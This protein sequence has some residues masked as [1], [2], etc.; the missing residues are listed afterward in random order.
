LGA[1]AKGGTTPL[2]DVFLYG[3]RITTRGFVFMDTPGFDPPCTTGL[4]AGGANV[5]V[6]TT[7]RGSVLGLKPTPCIKV[8]TNTPMYERMIDD[9]DLDA[10][11]ILEG[12]PVEVA[13][14]R[15]F[16]LI[17]EVADGRETKSERSG[18]GEEEFA[19]WQIGPIL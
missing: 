9:M 3:E 2:M 18:I 15:I 16:E 4:I 7:G 5:L 11:T 17:L 6:F 19:P 13:G 8:A 1:V 14:R 10:G 12:E